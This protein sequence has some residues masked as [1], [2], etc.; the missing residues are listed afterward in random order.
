MKLLQMVQSGILTGVTS[1]AAV[2]V[3]A[4]CDPVPPPRTE[5]TTTKPYQ[6]GGGSDKTMDHNGEVSGSSDPARRE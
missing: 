1:A 5:E 3:L 2:L 6:M 4:A